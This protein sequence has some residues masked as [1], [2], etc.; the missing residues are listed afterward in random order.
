[1]RR[2]AAVAA[3][4]LFAALPLVGCGD[5]PDTAPHERAIRRVVTSF[6]AAT[7]ARACELL[8]PK[9]LV[10][11][12]GG[13]GKGNYRRARANC[14]ARSERFEPDRIEI[15]RAEVIDDEL[16]TGRVKAIGK[17]GRREYTVVLRRPV[18]D[19][20]IDQITQRP[21]EPAD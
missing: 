19:W 9:A 13:K 7:D 4:V 16:R 5:D 1:M 10:R 18:D 6:A 11:V 17:R 8:T 3:A 20:L 14:V 21:V 15:T 2:S 12:Y